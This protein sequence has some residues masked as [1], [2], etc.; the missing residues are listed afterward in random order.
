[1]DVI[2]FIKSCTVELKLLRREVSQ[3]R[4]ELSVYRKGA[5]DVVDVDEAAALLGVAPKT[6]RNRISAGEF[7]RA[8]QKLPNGGRKKKGWLLRT[9]LEHK[10]RGDGHE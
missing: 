7:P 5:N 10:L 9:I 1:M 2:G 4:S 8:D 3:L 6:L